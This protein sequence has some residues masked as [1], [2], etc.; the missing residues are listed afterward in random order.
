LS[1]E[2]VILPMKKFWWGI[3]GGWKK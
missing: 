3:G 2:S 1:G